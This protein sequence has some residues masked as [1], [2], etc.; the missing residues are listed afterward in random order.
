MRSANKRYCWDV[1]TA[2]TCSQCKK[3]Y[4]Q[5]MS[6]PRGGLSTEDRV[7]SL[8]IQLLFHYWVVVR[9]HLCGVRSLIHFGYIW[10]M[11]NFWLSPSFN[12]SKSWWRL[13]CYA[14][15]SLA[16]WL[17]TFSRRTHADSLQHKFNLSTAETLPCFTAH[18][19]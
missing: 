2:H 6:Y 15:P 5:F 17:A 7:F 9:A 19:R 10:Q 4:S 13:S 16:G 11:T 1:T 3:Y 14:K 18:Q 12:P 8:R